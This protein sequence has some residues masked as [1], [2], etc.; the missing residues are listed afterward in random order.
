M[1]IRDSSRGRPS[2]RSTLLVAS[3]AHSPTRSRWVPAIWIVICATAASTPWWRTCARMAA[4]RRV[5]WSPELV[6]DD[7]LRLGRG[8]RRLQVGTQARHMRVDSNSWRAFS[9]RAE[10]GDLAV[11]EIG[12]QH[13][14]SLTPRQPRIFSGTRTRPRKHTPK[15]S[16]LVIPN[17]GPA[18]QDVR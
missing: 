13:V 12:P 8:A 4:V 7:D 5:E 3:S 9:Q 2:A 10:L 6:L 1:C 17:I 18:P 15:V 16:E 14:T 11:H